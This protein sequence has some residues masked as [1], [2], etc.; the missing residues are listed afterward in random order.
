MCNSRIKENFFLDNII[1]LVE[2]VKLMGNKVAQVMTT[3]NIQKYY[4]AYISPFIYLVNKYK[5]VLKI[6]HSV[7]KNRPFEYRYKF[8]LNKMGDDFFLNNMNLLSSI[9]FSGILAITLSKL[10]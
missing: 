1:L 2:G 10:E 8:F 6:K 7:D 9:L 3:K 4:L 5:T